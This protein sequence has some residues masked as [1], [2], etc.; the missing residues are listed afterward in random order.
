MENLKNFIIE[1]L[2][3]FSEDKLKKIFQPYN[4]KV[5]PFGINNYSLNIIEKHAEYKELSYYFIIRINTKN[6]TFCIAQHYMNYKSLDDVDEKFQ[7]YNFINKK[8]EVDKN[9]DQRNHKNATIQT[10][11]DDI[12][13]AFSKENF[14]V[15]LE[16]MKEFEEKN[17][18]KRDINKLRKEGEKRI[19]KVTPKIVSLLKKYENNSG[20]SYEVL[21]DQLIN[22]I[23]NIY[24]NKCPK[25]Y[26]NNLKKGLNPYISNNFIEIEDPDE[27]ISNLIIYDGW[28]YE[29]DPAT[30]DFINLDEKYGESSICI[31]KYG[32]YIIL[33]ELIDCE[34]PQLYLIK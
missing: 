21:I 20:I 15:L 29:I 6:N 10:N 30:I 4:I 1:S 25:K 8:W 14:K 13:T 12:P 5:T 24:N 3:K 19:Q 9:I 22:K 18:P 2:N 34:Y 27:K 7:T 17:Y 23:D 28:D 33:N 26:K 11:L 32:D 16:Y 31:H